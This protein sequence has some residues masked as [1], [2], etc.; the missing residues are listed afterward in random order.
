MPGLPFP[1]EKIRLI[2][3]RY[4]KN[5]IGSTVSPAEKLDNMLINKY[6]VQKSLRKAT[7]STLKS[8]GYKGVRFSRNHMIYMLFSHL[9]DSLSVN[10]FR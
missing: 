2:A 8:Y 6:F 1:N 7:K 4:R 9:P 10:F 3:T 5:R